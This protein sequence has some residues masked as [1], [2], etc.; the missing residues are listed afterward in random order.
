MVWKSDRAG[1]KDAPVSLLHSLGLNGFP[2]SRGKSQILEMVVRSRSVFLKVSSSSHLS[3]HHLGK[4]VKVQVLWLR[5]GGGRTPEL[6]LRS[7]SPEVLIPI[8]GFGNLKDPTP[9]QLSSLLS[10][11]PPINSSPSGLLQIPD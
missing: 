1:F 10:L 11:I 7:A 9:T 6:T 8:G 3:Q 5:L 4:Q 2:S